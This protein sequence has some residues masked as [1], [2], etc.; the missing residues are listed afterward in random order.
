M[1]NSRS[2]ENHEAE[3]QIHVA[4]VKRHGQSIVLPDDMDVDDA[5]DVLK[6]VRSLEEEDV[7]IHE[8]FP[9]FLFDAALALVKALEQKFG[10][11]LPKTG[12]M[13]SAHQLNVEVARG[14]TIAVPWGRFSLPGLGQEGYIQ[15]DIDYLEDRVALQVH[16]RVKRKYEKA[17]KEL[18]ELTR[19]IVA[20]ESI[21]RGK[22][23]EIQF[24]DEDGDLKSMPI[25]RFLDL[26]NTQPIFRRS[27]ESDID[28]YILTPIKHSDAVRRQKIP[29]KRGILLAGPYGTGKTLA[30][31]MIANTAVENGWTFLYVRNVEELPDALQFAEM[32]QP[33][34]IFAEDVDRV[35]GLERD[36]DVNELLNTLDGVDG[37]TREVMTV[38]TTN[39]VSQIHPAF[40]RAGRTDAILE[41][42]PPDAEAVSRLIRQYAGSLLD[43]N[44][45]L[46]SVSKVLD[47][48][49][50]STVREVVERSKLEAIRRTDGLG[51]EKIAEVDLLA[52]AEA[53]KSENLLVNHAQSSEDSRKVIAYE[54]GKGLGSE[55]VNG[56]K[57]V[58]LN[59]NHNGVSSK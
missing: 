24:R 50:A 2:N 17:V 54:M 25:P 40:L 58:M 59:S 16:V 33:C 23:I 12:L 30:A 19:E 13:M 36:D 48:Q 6:R 39:H 26:D 4:N 3:Q 28:T 51:G 8:T 32:Y 31:Q 55:V 52:A 34:V 18:L 29:L 14:K 44:E 7:V 20:K 49:I 57:E 41:V 27:L 43:P 1:A 21:Y 47:G 10:W 11:V 37:K 56:M 42:T 5:I 38:L 53:K 9:G 35:A 15:T 22:A 46:T 45:D